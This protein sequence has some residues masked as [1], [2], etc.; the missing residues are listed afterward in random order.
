MI[1]KQT[2]QSWAISSPEHPYEGHRENLA[3]CMRSLHNRS[4]MHT[5]SAALAF[6]VLPSLIILTD[7]YV[8]K[9]LHSALAIQH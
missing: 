8:Q 1:G 4:G 6:P 5:I 3:M 7:P 9:P 2:W